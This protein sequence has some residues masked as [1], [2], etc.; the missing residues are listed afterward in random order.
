MHLDCTLG[1][2]C[3]KSPLSDFEVWTNANNVHIIIQI[4]DNS[5]GWMRSNVYKY[6]S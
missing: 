1:G 2:S 6:M 4:V 3:G 5:V